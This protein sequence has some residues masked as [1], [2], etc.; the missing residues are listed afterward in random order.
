[1]NPDEGRNR[2]A[3]GTWLFLRALAVVHFIAFGSLWLQLEG[4]IGPNGVLPAGA[5]LEAV[6]EHLGGTA[7][8]Q[9]PTLCWWLGTDWGLHALCALG[10][11]SAIML[12]VGVAPGPSLVALWFAY[13]SLCGVGQ[14][15]FNF[16]WDALLLETT[17]MALWVSPW[18]WLPLWRR[19]EP[20]LIGRLLLVWLLFRLMFLSGAVKLASGD[21]TW[22]TL[23]ALAHHYETQPLPTMLGWYAHQL[24]VWFQ[25]MSCAVM[26]VIELVLPFFFWVRWRQLRHGAALATIGLMGLIA[27]TGNYT[28]FNLLTVA[29]CLPL[30]DDAFWRR[31]VPATTDTR[32]RFASR[33]MVWPVAAFVVVFT[34][35]QAVPS[36]WR[37]W[38]PPE[39]FWS[40]AA[41]VQPFRSLNNYGLFMV[42][43]TTRPE[44]VIEGSHDGRY[45][46]PYGFRHKP[47]DLA[48]RPTWVAPH[49]PRLDW[50]M[51]F[52]A[53]GRL[54]HNPWV[55]HLAE[56]LLKGTPAV[57]DLLAHNPFPEGPPRHLRAVRYEYRFTTRAERRESG[58][59]WERTPIDYY[60]APAS[61]R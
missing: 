6:R 45:W 4:L 14:V 34:A 30:L 20:P 47:G 51:W 40:V 21:A 2:Y 44:I 58:Q 49:Q 38:K 60:L 15:F 48:R 52:A 26:F 24:P 19:H 28:F 8:S 10:L 43:T 37:A 22:A 57:T 9:L 35:I 32:P 7:W 56:H 13:L 50:Q 36:V 1:M 3:T 53:L 31:Q 12:F 23:T 41:V 61:L 16:Q 59:W 5:Y 17:F 29:L 39:S 54:D 27:L 42:M 18:T 25:R 33:W 11:V 46:L 55:L